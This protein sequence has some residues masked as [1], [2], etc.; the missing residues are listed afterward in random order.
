MFHISVDSNQTETK[1][2]V[3]FDDDSA[4]LKKIGTD[5]FERVEIKIKIITTK[6]S[7]PEIKRTQFLLMLAWAMKHTDACSAAS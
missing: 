2:C 3:E 6:L 5:K 4:C 1:M 7:S